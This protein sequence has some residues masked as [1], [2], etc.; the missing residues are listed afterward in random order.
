MNGLLCG[1]N[2]TQN[3]P[4]QRSQ[5]D[6]RLIVRANVVPSD[7]C[8]VRTAPFERHHHW[9]EREVT[10]QDFPRTLASSAGEEMET[11]FLALE[12]LGTVRSGL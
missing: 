2:S 3:S 5:F 1:H 9:R 4:E 10:T 7:S 12:H 11:V 8:L 6:V